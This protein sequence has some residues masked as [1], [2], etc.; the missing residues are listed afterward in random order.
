VVVVLNGSKVAVVGEVAKREKEDRDDNKKAK[1]PGAGFF[2]T[3]ALIFFFWS[4]NSLIFIGGE[5][6]IFCL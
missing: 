4:W 5:R 2:P 3:L 1:K 6:G